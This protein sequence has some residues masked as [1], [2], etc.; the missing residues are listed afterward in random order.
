VRPA[1]DA[2]IPPVPAVAR[3]PA[4]PPRYVWLRVAVASADGRATP[5]L[6]QV[7]A[8]TE[9]ESYLE[10]LPA[11]YNQR[12]AT[13][14]LRNWLELYR[15]M[16]GQV[17]DTLEA[18]PQRLER[19]LAPDA[20]LDWLAS[21]LA[22]DPPLGQDAAG[23]RALLARV[24]DLYRRRGTRRGLA[25]MVEI[26]AGVRPHIF[27]AFADRQVWQL[28]ESSVL[29]L[30]TALA[31]ALPDGIVVPDAE[32]DPGG[33]VVGQL[34]VGAVDPQPASAYG[35]PLFR[36]DA[37]RFVAVVSAAD[38]VDPARRQALCTALEAEKPAHTD[39]HLCVIGPAM[40]IGLQATVGVD[41][42]VGGGAPAPGVLGME[43][44]VESV[45]ADESG[46]TNSGRIGMRARL[47]RDTLL[48]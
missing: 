33:M 12:D 23:L 11:V 40:R 25:E 36:D 48:G 14:F 29:G 43:L 31:P 3:T 17:E 7:H 19:T 38:V 21:W 42:I 44:G 28:G 4:H 8:E 32:A 30:D 39:F 9:G 10:H 47:G 5:R 2:L 13:G 26:Y 35:E 1:L 41:S 24:P 37:H 22:F 6:N 45:M 34:V 20:D 16:M 18:M 27:E 15:A 46:E